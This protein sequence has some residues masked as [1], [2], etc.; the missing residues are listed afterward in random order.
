M[1]PTTIQ[2]SSKSVTLT[3]GASV[4]DTRCYLKGSKG[5]VFEAALELSPE[6]IKS[7]AK[8]GFTT[9]VVEW[10]PLDITLNC[11][12]NSS[13]CSV[14][15]DSHNRS[16]FY[17]D[18]S[19]TLREWCWTDG[20]GWKQTNFEQVNVMIGTNVAA[21]ALPSWSRGRGYILYQD[22]AGFICIREDTLPDAVRRTKKAVP[23]SGI[24]VCVENP[25]EYY[26]KIH[27][28][29]QDESLAI[30]EI[31]LDRNG[32]MPVKEL[33]SKRDIVISDIA[34]IAPV[35][36]GKHEIRLYIQDA[37]G[38]VIECKRAGAGWETNH[39]TTKAMACANIV[40]ISTVSPSLYVG[41][42]WVSQ[43]RYL[44]V[45]DSRGGGATWREPAALVF[46]ERSR[47]KEGSE[48]SGTTPLD[49]PVPPSTG[50]TDVPV[51]TSREP[52]VATPKAEP[53]PQE[54]N[55]PIGQ[56]QVPPPK[57]GSDHE[58][59]AS[60]FR[61]PV[62]PAK[63]GTPVRDELQ[64]QPVSESVPLTNGPEGLQQAD[65][66]AVPERK[67]GERTVKQDERAPPNPPTVPRREQKPAPDRVQPPQADGERQGAETA[68]PRPPRPMPKRKPTIVMPTVT[69]PTLPADPVA[70][71]GRPPRTI[72]QITLSVSERVNGIKLVYENGQETAWRGTSSGEQ[73]VFAL[74][75][76]EYVTH[77]WYA[78][79]RRSIEGILFGTSSGRKSPWYGQEY[80]LY[81]LLVNDGHVLDDL[82]GPEDGQLTP[83]MSEWVAYVPS[84][85]I[86]QYQDRYATLT[87]EWNRFAASI[88][89]WEGQITSSR[90]GINDLGTEQA[91][92]KLTELVESVEIYYQLETGQ[93]EVTATRTKLRQD[94]LKRI[95]KSARDVQAAFA[96]LVA[97]L[98]PMSGGLDSISAS[99]RSDGEA[100]LS[101]LT[102]LSGEL[103]MYLQD[104]DERSGQIRDEQRH[105]TEEG[106]QARTGFLQAKR[107]FDKNM[108]SK[109]AK[110]AD[111]TDKDAPLWGL[112]E[113]CSSLKIGTI[114]TA[115]E[116]HLLSR[117]MKAAAQ[118][119]Y[120]VS[121]GAFL[122]GS[123][124]A[125]A[126]GKKEAG[127]LRLNLVRTVSELQSVIARLESLQPNGTAT[128]QDTSELAA[129]ING[130]VAALDAFEHIDTSQEFA[131]ILVSV[132]RELLN[133]DNFKWNR[134]EG[135]QLLKVS[136]DVYHRVV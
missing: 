53:T 134:E 4:N 115:F 66:Q 19:N 121:H 102:A 88:A 124:Q 36:N 105:W 114:E 69:S 67:R 13:L 43:D 93:L 42:L 98:A 54:K 107:S 85:N 57:G 58:P 32:W 109:G 2:L 48:G 64:K 1:P 11:D 76:G 59:A 126:D 100:L 120:D 89:D 79:D 71:R 80:G 81:G 83:L 136:L 5:E 95:R 123:I 116:N 112:R 10:S 39:L 44:Y 41:V 90:D 130:T 15:W 133:N 118:V 70:A 52:G 132:L 55:K 9:R 77:V 131:E 62:G 72:V 47:R 104:L 6:F 16:V 74:N 94:I 82:H 119:Q 135:D 99:K 86:V 92:E 96:A 122:Q 26:E 106:E 113:W 3:A 37:Q 127:T 78:T 51:P 60:Q 30:R 17:Q 103:Q 35:I 50:P 46:L 23:L 63:K 7:S 111:L 68:L 84:G 125:C 108:A 34:A 110:A 33:V 91:I 101:R 18:Q 128:Q 8:E 75:A 21:L 56:S 31:C 20:K 14:T 27:I 38:T 45:C 61:K 12:E 22:S 97:V 40:A 24:G 129:L 29:Y 65:G 28:Y 73:H 87:E 117:V 49:K 25:G